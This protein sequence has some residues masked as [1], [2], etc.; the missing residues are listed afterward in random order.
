MEGT[1]LYTFIAR[2]EN[3]VSVE[4]GEFVTVLNKEDKDWYW[5][6]R[7]DGLEGF[8]PTAFVYPAENILHTQEVDL[9]HENG[10]ITSTQQNNTSFVS[11]NINNAESRLTNDDSR[12]HHLVMLYDYKA[13]A[14]D[15]LSVR[16]GEVVFAQN[17]PDQTIDG[18]IWVFAP[19]AKRSGKYGFIP[20]AYT[21]PYTQPYR[22][23]TSV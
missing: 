11:L 2:D 6:V 18:W 19:K 17:D 1:F 20:K 23:N 22:P 5:V 3:D 14:P 9:S 10:I 21:A 13:Q 12:Y 4:R 7:S 16:R 8:V 15:D